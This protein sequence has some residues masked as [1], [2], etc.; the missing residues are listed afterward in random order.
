MYTQHQMYILV[1]TDVSGICLAA[2]NCRGHTE[3]KPE[4]L[5]E[6]EFTVGPEC[7]FWCPSGETSA[8]A[9]AVYIAMCA[10]GASLN[11]G[12]TLCDST[13]DSFND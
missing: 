9:V 11:S 7:V 4:T 12:D 2:G 13:Q 3:I 6:L 1:R 5:E 8:E 10:C